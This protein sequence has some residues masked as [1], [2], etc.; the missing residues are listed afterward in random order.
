[1][2][3]ET[4]LTNFFRR[5]II[6]KDALII[7]EKQARR[8]CNSLEN[9]NKAMLERWNMINERLDRIERTL[10]ALRGKKNV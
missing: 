2:A 7:F 9:D 6:L 3:G 10:S 4:A 1:V 5:K 8:F